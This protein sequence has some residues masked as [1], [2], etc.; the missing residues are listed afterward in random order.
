MTATYV[1][2]QL[3]RGPQLQVSWLPSEFSGKGGYVKLKEKGSWQ[4]GWKVVESFPGAVR[5]HEQ[6]VERSRDHLN[7]RKASDI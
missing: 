7:T 1:Q 6:V 4:D 2:C 3:Q 5:T